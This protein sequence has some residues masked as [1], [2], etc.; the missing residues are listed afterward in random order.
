MTFR[1]V[2]Y[3]D[4]SR[5]PRSGE[6]DAAVGGWVGCGWVAVDEGPADV[7]RQDVGSGSSARDA[8]QRRGGWWRGRTFTALLS[9]GGDRIQWRRVRRWNMQKFDTKSSDDAEETNTQTIGTT[10]QNESWRIKILFAEV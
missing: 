3:P 7:S 2:S 6:T 10:V 8:C 1:P 5:R 9:D 4:S